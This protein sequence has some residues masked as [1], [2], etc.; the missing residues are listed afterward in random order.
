MSTEFADSPQVSSDTA[1]ADKGLKSG[2]LSFAS[3]VVMGV[4]SAG[5]AYGMA[6]TL[7]F[8]VALVGVQTPIVLL[9]AFV[10]M[11]FT[12]IAYQQLNSAEPDC[13]TTFTWAARA[14][15]P[16]SGW[17]GGWAIIAA[18]L[19][20]MANAAQITGQYFFLLIGADGIGA[21]A[22]SGWVLLVGVLWIV[23]MTVISYIGVEVSARL[24]Q[25]LLAI[26]VIMLLVFAIFA[27]V[28]I[29]TATAGP[30]SIPVS[31]SWFNPFEVSDPGAFV[32]GFVLMLFLFWG[33]DTAVCVNEESQD[34]AKGPGRAGIVAT[35][36]LLVTY[37]LVTVSAQAFAG[38]GDSGIGLANPD[39]ANN[40]LSVLGEAVFGEGTFG[41]VL[42]HL[43]I[44]MVLASA[45]ASTQTTIMPTARTTLS[46]ATFRALPA[47]FGNLH[48]RFKTP[49]FS[50]ML[51]GALSV[52][53]YIVLNYVTTSGNLLADT[54]T[55]L[56]MLVAFYLGLTGFACVWFF[57][58]TLTDSRRNLWL[59]GVF[60]AIGGFIMFAVLVWSGYDS[61]QTGAGSS[62][63]T[64]WSMP[65][66][67]HWQIGGVFLIAAGSMLLGVALMAIMRFT[68]PAF[69]AGAT[70]PRSAA[71]KEASRGK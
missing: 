9:L 68:K 18:D 22:T 17:M 37:L 38:V 40:V 48:A 71:P 23:L 6:A 66:S 30:G 16:R 15:G 5:P 41:V 28:R 1:P 3:N 14:F 63:Y 62:S 42:T 45:A 49:S 13:G 29:L 32:R 36:L 7:G 8:V 69:F 31:W 25:A 10:P 21:N 20:V 35:L 26:E 19:L 67:P 65:F 70:L 34:R 39:N 57:R 58:H 55:A 53:I 24:Q 33:W 44:L 59:R 46:M 2:A 47:A 12:A 54:V 11:L 56:T 43:L 64:V 50:T 52:L 60:P 4:A 27:V 51:F 61:W